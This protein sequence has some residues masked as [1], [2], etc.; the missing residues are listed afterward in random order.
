ML[1]SFEKVWKLIIVVVMVYDGIKCFEIKIR[2]FRH[3]TICF[4]HVTFSLAKYPKLY[5]CRINTCFNFAK[6]RRF[7]IQHEMFIFQIGRLCY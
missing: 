7:S 2:L 5:K 6:V 3:V 1:E 4:R